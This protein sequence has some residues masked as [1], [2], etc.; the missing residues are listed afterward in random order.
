MQYLGWLER[1]VRRKMDVKEEDASTVGR[2]CSNISCACAMHVQKTEGG[3]AL[4]CG[5][6]KFTDSKQGV[7]L[8]SRLTCWSKQGG[9]P[10]VQIITLWASAAVA[11][12]V[13]ADLGQLF[14]NA[15][16]AC[17]QIRALHVSAARS[18]RVWL[19][20]K[21]QRWSEGAEG[22]QGQLLAGQI[23]HSK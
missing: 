8:A 20:D 9:D 5:W 3:A 4:L 6:L 15:F 10:V 18:P 16:R 17:G 13:Q 7:L 1:I 12:R 21:E 11:G 22:C 14:L 23:V 2:A 19:L